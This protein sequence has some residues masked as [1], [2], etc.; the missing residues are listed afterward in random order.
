MEP[1][2]KRPARPL[3]KEHS[4]TTSTNSSD[5]A[6]RKH[7]SMFEL[8]VDQTFEF[9]GGTGFGSTLSSNRPL[10]AMPP[11]AAATTAMLQSLKSQAGGAA[12]AGA[13]GAAAGAAAAAAHKFTFTNSNEYTSPKKIPV[14]P[15]TVHSPE[16][17]KDLQHRRAHSPVNKTTGSSALGS[18]GLNAGISI[19]SSTGAVATTGTKSKREPS[20]RKFLRDTLAQAS[21]GLREDDDEDEYGN[22]IRSASPTAMDSANQEAKKLPATITFMHHD[23][24]TGATTV[25]TADAAA[26]AA[27]DNATTFLKSGEDAIAFFARNGSD[28]EVKF[29]HLNRA[30]TGIAFR[31]YDLT[32]VAQED[33]DDEHFT[34]SSSGLVHMSPG[35]PS[36]FIAL[37]EWMRQSTLFNVLTSF[38]YFKYYLVNKAFS[39]WGA[40]V[41]FKLYCRQRKKLKNKLYLAKESFCVPLLQVKKVMSMEV[42]SVVL[43]DL[44][45]QKTYESG[46]FVEYQ[47]TKRAEGSKQFEIC[48]EKLQAI[49]QKVCSDVKNLTKTSDAQ[50]DFLGDGYGASSAGYGPGQEKTKSIVAVKSE[51]QQRK[52]LFKRAAE[53]A[54]M[55]SD[56]IRLVDYIAVESFVVLAIQSCREFLQELSKVPRK[57][58]LFETTIYFGELLTLFQP[59]CEQIQH[60]VVSMTDDIV[61]TVNSVSRVLYLRPFAPYVANVVADA[62]HVGTTISNSVDFQQIRRDLVTKIISDYAEAADYVKIFDNVRPIYEYDKVWDFDEYSQR[63]HTVTTLKADMLQ[64][65]TWEKEL[66]KMRAGQTIGILH[67]ESRKLKQT[68]IPMTTAKLDA[69]KGLVKDLAR[70]KCKNQLIEYKQRIQALLQRPQHLKEF[71]AH[72]ERVQQLKSKQKALLKN[73]N[74]VDELYRLLGNYGVRISSEDMVQLDDLRSV[75][76]SYKEETDAVE[77]FIQSRLGE[78]TQQLD[79][80]IQRLDE[81][82]LQLNSQLQAGVFIDPDQFEDPSQVKAELDAMK[83]R[84]TQLDELSKQYTEYQVLFNLTPFKYL[85]LQ[86]TQEFFGTVDSLWTAVEKWNLS[87][88]NAMTSSFAEVNAE[89]LAK[90]VA[91]AFKD[92]YALHKKLSNDVT[93]LLKDRTADFKVKIPTILELGNPAMK[94]RHWEK[95]F[96]ALR[97][98]WYPGIMFTLENLIAY[99]V[100][101]MKELVSEVSSTASGEAQ[102][103]AS[104]MKIKHGWDQMQFVCMNHRDQKEVF[105]LGSLEEILMLLEDNQVT[106]QTMMGSRYIMG[107]KDE[108]DRWNK[109]LSLLSETLDEWIT[110][111]RSWMYLETIFCA[112]DIQK[113]LPVEAQKFALVDKNWKNTMM[114]TSIDPSVIRCVEN[115]SDILDQFRFSNRILEEIQKSLEDYLETKRM[116]FPRFYFLSN[117]ELLE[118]LSQTRD[119]R[120]VQPHLGKCFDAMKSI[121]FGETAPNAKAQNNLVNAMISGEGEIV[122]FPSLVTAQGPVELW[123]VEVEKAMRASLYEDGVKALTNYPIENAIDRR[124]WLFGYS[125]QVIILVDQVFWTKNVTEAIM[126]VENNVDEHA[127]N[128]FL[129]FSLKQI[130]GMVKLVRGQLSKL[131]RILMGAIITIDVH[132]RDVVRSLEES[133]V[134]SLSDFEWTRQLRYYWEDDIKNFVARQTNTRF[135]YAFE[136]LGNTPRLVITPLTDICYMTLTGALHLRLGGAPAGPAGTGKTETTKDLAKA[137]AVQCVVFNCSDGLDYKIMGRFFSGLAQAGAWA[138]FDEFNRIDIEV[139]SVIAQQV[140]C[141][142]QAIIADVDQFEFEGKTIRLNKGFGVFITMNPGYAGRT[143]LPDNL[144]ALFRPVAMM[145]PDYRLIAEIVLFSEGFANALP[146]SHKMT[147]LYSLSS[148]QLSKQD[149]YDFGMRAVKSVLVA[150]GQLKRKEPDM[151]EDL[152]LIRAMRDSNVPKFLEQD[153]PLFRGII[154]DLFPGVVVPFVD[155]GQLQKAIE[156]QLEILN[157]Q[158]VPSFITKAIQVHETQLVRHGMMLVGEAGSGKSTNCY[159]LARALTQLFEDGVVD[160]DGFYKEVHRLILNPKSIS[161]GQLYGEFNLL[162][163]EWA[164]GLVPKLVRQCVSEAAESDNRNWVVFDGPVDAVWIENMNTVL[165]DNKTLCLSNSERIKLPSTLHMMFEVQ[166][167]RVASPATV[168]R[169]GMVYMEQVHVGICSLARTWKAV[170]LDKILS[171]LELCHMLLQLIETHVPAAIAFVREHCREKVPSNDANLMQSCLNLLASCLANGAAQAGSNVTD[172]AALLRMYFVFAV[173]WSVG[174]NIDDVSRA[175]FNDFCLKQLQTLIEGDGTSALIVDNVYDVVIDENTGNWTS[176]VDKTPKFTF[177]PGASYFSMVVPTQDTARFRYLLEKLLLADHHVLY[178]GETGVGKSVIIQSF[179]DDM[180]KTDGCISATMSYSAQTKPRNLYEQFELKLEKKRKN[181]LGPP[182]GKRML[183]FVDDLNMPALEVYGAQP[184]NELLRQIIDQGG[185]YDTSKMFFKNIKDVVFAAAC[186]PPGGGRSEVTPRLLRHFHMVWIPNLSADVMR[187]IFASILGGFLGTEL[188]LLVQMAAPI[189]NASVILYQEVEVEMLPTPSKSHYTFNLR[190]LSK[191]FQGILMVKKESVSSEEG[192]LKLWLHEEARVFRDR[193]IDAADRA[194]FNATCSDLLL[195][196]VRLSWPPEKFENLLYGDYLTRDNKMYRPVDDLAR[197]GGL[198]TE[199]L[200]EYNITFPSQ[201]HLVFFHDAMHHISRI[202]RV[203]RQP[204]GNALLVGVGGSGRQ[205]LTRLAAFMAEYKCFSIEI[206]R[207][208]GANEFHED[209][210]KILMTAGAE[211]KPVVFLFSDAQIVQESFLEDINNVLNTGDVPNLYAP[212]ELE[213]IVGMVRPLAAQVGKVTRED[214]L[215]YYITLVREN[216]HVVL[217]FSPIGAGFRNRCRM[218]PS[219]VNCCTIDWFNAWPEDALNSVAKRFFASSAEELGIEAHVDTLCKMAVTIHRSVEEATAQYYEQLR[220]RNYTTPT[221]YLELIKLYV[222]MLRNQRLVV[223]AKEARYRGGLKKLFETEEVVGNLKRSLTDLQPVLIK[224]QEDTSV[225]LVQVAKD[226]AD[227]DAQQKLI[228][229]DV[230]A[231]NK[232]AAEVKAIKDDCQK[233]LDEAM[234]AYYASIKA[235]GLLKKD[236]ITVLKTFTNPP[237]LVGVTMNAVCLLFNAKQEWNE[238]KKLLNDMKF[239]DKLKDFDKDNIPP[240]TIRQ[241]AKFMQDDEFTPE[242]LSSISTAATSL[243]MWVR[244]MYT[245]DAVAKN[246]APKKESLKQAE[247]RLDEEQQ[248]LSVKQAGLNEILKK[249]ADLKRTLENAQQKKVDLEKQTNKTQAQL[250]RA[251]RLIDSLGEEQGRWKECAENLAID[252]VNLV[253]DMILSAGCIAYLGPFTAEYR[254]E[255]QM[256]WI[257]ACKESGLPVDHGFSFQ[258]VLADP[259]VVREWNI[260]G[261]PADTFSIENGLFTTMGRRW[262]LMIDPQGQANKWIKNMYKSSGALQIIK[263]T[264]KDFLST[265]E[266]AIRY[267][268]PILLENVEEDLDPSL[269]PVLLKQVFKRGGQLLLHLGDS[270]VPYSENFRFYITTKLA[271][272]H[273][274]PEICIKVTIINFT[275]TLTGLEDQLLVDVVRSERPDLE[276]RKNELTVNI[277]SDKKQLKEIEDKILYMLENSQGNIL[278]DE[279]LIDTLAHSKVTSSAIKTRMAEAET[280]SKEI[281]QTREGYRCVAIR[282]SIIYFAIASLAL[283]DPMY[284]YSLQF[285]QKLFVMRLENSAKSEVLETRLKIL[286]EDITSSMFINVCRGLFEK[287]KIVYAFMIASSILLQLGAILPSEWNYYLV[288]DK[289][290]SAAQA[291]ATN[292]TKLQRPKWMSDRVWKVLHGMKEVS[293][294]FHDLPDSVVGHSDAWKKAMVMSDLPHAE[295]LPTPWHGRLTNF[296]KL[297]VL[298]VFREEMLVFGTREFVGRELGKLFTESPPFDLQGCYRDSTPETPLIFVL[299]PGADIND[300]LLELAKQEGKDGSGLKIISLGQGQG[301]IAEALMKQAKET[302]DWVCLQNCHLAVSWLGR[303][304]QILEQSQTEELHPEFRLWLTSMPSSRF[305]VPILQ[306]G[307][308]ITNEPPKGIKANLGRTFLDMKDADYEGCSKPREFKKLLFALAFYN[309][310]CLER[311]KFGAVGWNIPYEWMNSDLKTGMQQVKLY[312]EEQE[313][314][315]YVTLNVMVADISYG[316]RITDRWDKRTNSS[317]MRKLFCKALMDDKYRFTASSAYYAPAEGPL[318]AVRDYVSALPTVDAPEI[319]GLHPNA[320]ITFQQ[321][322]TQALLDT[323]LRMLGGGGGGGGE[324]GGGGAQSNDSVVMEMVVAIQERMPELFSESQA[325]ATTFKEVAGGSRNSL[326][327]FLSQEMIRFNVLI[328]VMKTTL[329]MLKRA[330]KGLVVMSGPLEKMYNGFLIQKIPRE[331]EDAGYPCLKPLAAWIEDF[332]ARIAFTQDWLINGPPAT[333]WL[334]GFFFPQGF[335]TAVKQ[336]YS[337]D[338]KIAID[339]LIVSCEIMSKDKEAYTVSPPYGVYVYGLFMEGARF[340]RKGMMMAESIPNELFD[341][342]PAIWL[343]PMK[344]EAYKP[345]DVYECPLYKTSIRAGTLSTT[346]HSTNFVVA[347]DIPTDKDPDHWIRRGCAML[348]MLDT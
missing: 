67:V 269:E 50:D 46:A 98:P 273:Y 134:A 91:V 286:M 216:L 131:Q 115:G 265:L 173:T 197:F 329:E 60:I 146:L 87:Y 40:N 164:D 287:D 28:S 3:R 193:L 92:A 158:Q 205:S 298:R 76:E 127:I 245:Y 337:R 235:L 185:Y 338:K 186:A 42:L 37:A 181:L 19:A 293:P 306:N 256:K 253:G 228:Q 136:Y 270:D 224:A 238:A 199:Y 277:A 204:R 2:K 112:E 223:R 129:Q 154:A 260:M 311:R 119:P 22:P 321:K 348:C 95:I 24:V 116:A 102:I 318:A 296:Q 320:D 328:R 314:V 258:R 126:M 244:A 249:V 194:W 113:Q 340:D 343:K 294:I 103:E 225:L 41:R 324:G 312:L 243:C 70:A 178:S 200:E 316:G 261:L 319:F 176:W 264:Q 283:V 267:G 254:H 84:L 31:P 105:I 52:K 198:L 308:K 159:V 138:C 282:G 122:Q 280:T 299:S 172:L 191:V 29:V 51:Q 79:V 207:G 55:I 274:M 88:N 161:A 171:S 53:E 157:L 114:R 48:I 300:Y 69:M 246:I 162:T 153:L 289:R 111:Q 66:E 336:S 25:T 330:I 290:S 177:Q 221:S 323:V 83:Q 108:V 310:V 35:N 140:L 74:V 168:S 73:T 347:L 139:L 137:L 307:I 241:L 143:E 125:A 268:A 341:R 151:H 68:L 278:D 302:G 8:N 279:E 242:T 175:K 334:S 179:L 150:A 346:G 326:G 202:C 331:W 72:V 305:P 152:L 275:V 104:L 5:A 196:H 201:M 281:D 16:K 147:Q 212:D 56:L 94:D 9:D 57:T 97:Q 160:R 121:R 61:S 239:L 101:E 234:P 44:R 4:A 58:G 237:R 145:V 232:I 169:C 203:L 295:P 59:T 148:E 250:V 107:V 165:D 34:M 276:Q 297:L 303:L 130:D 291:A 80:N 23:P 304:E 252:M 39:L 155:Y 27:A 226:Q 266:N 322:E 247:S 272:P 315:P 339:A 229:A 180:A 123:L 133:K 187:R 14:F 15:G 342:M 284:Q 96:K 17:K 156:K 128:G 26:E 167:L 77:G 215:Q 209:L 163:N 1:T 10:R 65:S 222:D 271:N 206:T 89:E 82:V 211:N 190:D 81:Q 32:V 251:E 301:P 257:T 106:L 47:A 210:K 344:R 259:V 213:K 6:T 78:M 183:F 240:K 231:A 233:D 142:Q 325:H 218:F 63:A 230:E 236:D 93:A 141:I 332:F 132:A 71:A 54:A 292:A 174:A 345:E 184:P 166:D 144:K 118:I 110:C 30:N 135:L 214:I 120:A 100:L 62:P 33:I 124:D 117:D 189:V 317:I 18:P 220:R 285:Y 75:Q 188:P 227:A 64:I 43:L 208:Y 11:A 309:A 327:V 45:A 12:G 109:R 7:N 313:T 99:D 90:D 85:N 248:K 195:E 86:A 49:I 335:M 263:L 255:L 149:H 288:G 182:A 20:P 333:Y 13:A 219:L 21:L 262:P 192:L 217:A 36:E 38:R 170:V